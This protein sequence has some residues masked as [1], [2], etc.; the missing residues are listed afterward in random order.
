[1]AVTASTRRHLDDH[2]GQAELAL[3][4]AANFDCLT[5]TPAHESVRTALARV[6]EARDWVKEKLTV[7]SPVLKPGQPAY[8]SVA[9]QRRI[10][11]RRMAR[12]A[13]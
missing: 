12:L 5:G 8:Q 4:I 3:K 6:R 2:L 10:V 7:E 1:M 9:A 13:P 11:Q